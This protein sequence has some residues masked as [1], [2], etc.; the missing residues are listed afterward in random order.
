MHTYPS[1][2]MKLPQPIRIVFFVGIEPDTNRV[3]PIRIMA[4][5]VI[6][7]ITYQV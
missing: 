4:D 2:L 1:R 5:V 6:I 7:F 3:R